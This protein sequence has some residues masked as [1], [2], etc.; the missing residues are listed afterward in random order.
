MAAA[1]ALLIE[2]NPA[3]QRM[4]GLEIRADMEMSFEVE[5]SN[6]LWSGVQKLETQKFDVVLLDLSL[7]DANGLEG[8][9]TLTKRWPDLAIVVLTGFDD[10]GTALA[11]LK[12]GAQDYISKNSLD[13]AVLIRSLQ[14]A[15]E[16]KRIAVE[17]RRSEQRYRAL[18]AAMTS[19]VWSTDASG[20]MN[21]TQAVWS[22][23]TGQ[24]WEQYSRHGWIDALHADDRRIFE[25]F[26]RTATDRQTEREF[27]VR[28]WHESSQR[29]RRCIARLVPILANGVEVDEWVGTL[30][31]VEDTRQAEELLL[32][33]ER[34]AALGTLAA[35]IAHEI[36]NPIVA[37]WTSA[38]AALN[39][40]DKPDSSDLLLE[41]LQ[42][43]IQSVLR[44][45]DTVEGVLH[46]A[47]H[48]EVEQQECDITHAVRQ[49]V[50]EIQHYAQS[51]EQTLSC[52]SSPNLPSIYG[53]EKQIQRVLVTLLRNAIEAGDAGHTV[54][55][56]A[57]SRDGDVLITVTDVGRGMTAME[58]RR[59]FDP[60]FT[61]RK[62][63]GMGLGLSIAHGIME[64]HRG[65]IELVSEQGRGTT[66]TLRFPATSSAPAID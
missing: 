54:D 40:L 49:A 33:T 23:Y 50:S 9:L 12:E 59:A 62:A 17:L 66:A 42:N 45:R 58:L 53:N 39:V 6:S 5:A 4:I 61:S 26:W 7:P 13:G 8:V 21:D 55:V 19:I 32:R 34:L 65:S 27:P 11:A 56:T 10:K 2:D 41:C 16:R 24:A 30:T 52:T 31:D 48:G 47:R 37:A 46:F 14:Y 60:F 64:C 29:Y 57:L 36:N 51:H 38:E 63:N 22:D 1:F 35:G 25:A 44:C 28:V 20:A 18:V 43:V 3:D 15:I